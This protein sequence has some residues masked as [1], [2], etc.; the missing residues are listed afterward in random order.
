[1][2]ASLLFVG[3]ANRAGWA[4]LAGSGKHLVTTGSATFLNRL[5]FVT[6]LLLAAGAGGFLAHRLVGSR[7]SPLTAAPAPAQ[8]P[9]R[10]LAPQSSSEPE[11]APPSRS[12]PE[13]LPEISLSDGDGVR[14]KL[15]D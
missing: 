10:T 1:M 13:R 5:V 4:R 9:A 11:I 3:G 14:H 7:A 15:S 8:R 2:C 6:A 12:I